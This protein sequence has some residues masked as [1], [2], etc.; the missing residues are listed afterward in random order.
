MDLVKLLLRYLAYHLLNTRLTPQQLDQIINSDPIYEFKFYTVLGRVNRRLEQESLRRER[1]DLYQ[2]RD[3]DRDF[4]LPEPPESPEG[5][6][7]PHHPENIQSIEKRYK[8][9][10]LFVSK[11]I[12]FAKNYK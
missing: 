6:N 10:S 1:P 3:L 12:V 2:G 8:P 9:R 11:N 5:P 7:P 4:L